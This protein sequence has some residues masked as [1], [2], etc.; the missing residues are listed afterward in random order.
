MRILH[1]TKKY[2]DAFGGDAVIVSN[3][4][5]EQT[6]LGHEIFILTPNC[7]EIREQEN[8]FK[9]GL[10]DK[11]PNLDRLTVRRFLSLF[12]LF[13]SGFKYFGS[14][15]PDVIHTH[16]AD[17]GFFIAISAKLYRIPVVNTCHGVSFPD[18]Q[19]SF[20]KRF[21]ERFFLKHAGFKRIIVVEK[22]ILKFFDDAGIK[23]GVYIPN[24]VD[25][26]QFDKEEA[27]LKADK[28]IR[29]LFVGRL[30]EQKGCGYL[31]Q[32]TRILIA[33]TENFVIKIVGDGSQ[34]AILENLTE[35]NNL[36]SYMTFLGGVEDE[37]LRELYRTS[38]VFIL[39]SIWEGLPVTLLEA[40]SAELPV[41]VT[42]VGAIRD[43]CVDEGNGLIVRPKDP[44]SIAE[45]ML[46]MIEDEE[47]RLKL[48]K[49][50][51]ELVRREFSLESV[52][53][54]TLDLYEDVII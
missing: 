2:P 47:L 15:K 42:N 22:N 18:K 1:L 36:G 52:V 39:P 35:E 25:I 29:F 45:A 50:G 30:E 10:R 23:N 34:R 20:I 13:F 32:A 53:M 26:G 11:A 24:G 21:A 49:N 14:L 3:L 19:Y 37:K 28:K 6:K 16:S 51:V 27:V 33:E 7:P 12:I 17:L 4:E 43:I 5:R 31:I 8:V 41:I 38:D 44:E 9:F 54:S 46:R 40:W 48:A